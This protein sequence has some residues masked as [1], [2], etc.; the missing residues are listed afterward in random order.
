MELCC[1]LWRKVESRKGCWRL[2]VYTRL[3]LC[4]RWQLQFSNNH[5]VTIDEGFTIP[6][7]QT[8]NGGLSL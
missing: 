2:P 7:L 1:H 6:I 4:L 3:S 8:G 5:S